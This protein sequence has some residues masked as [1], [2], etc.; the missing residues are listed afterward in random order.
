VAADTPL[1]DTCVCG[2]SAWH[3]HLNERV[4]WC[5]NCGAARLIFEPHWQIPLSRA[6]DVPPP[7]FDAD[8]TPTK[9]G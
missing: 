9:P 1:A 3:K 7:T 5:R 8:E 6:G 2:S 4:L